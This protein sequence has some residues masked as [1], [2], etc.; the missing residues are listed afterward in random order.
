MRLA[1]ILVLD[2]RECKCAAGEQWLD[3]VRRPAN[4]LL[5]FFHIPGAREIASIAATCWMV[6]DCAVRNAPSKKLSKKCASE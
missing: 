4:P 2:R 1:D 6:V 5:T 3:S